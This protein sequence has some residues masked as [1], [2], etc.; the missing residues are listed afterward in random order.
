MSINTENSY[1]YSDLDGLIDINTLGPQATYYYRVQKPV[2][3]NM[4]NF[5][6]KIAFYRANST[7]IYH[8][9]DTLAHW[10][11]PWQKIQMVKWSR[12]GNMAYFYEYKRNEVYDSI[13]LH[14][15]D[16]YCFRIDELKNNFEIVKSL[17]LIDT[18]FDTDSILEKFQSLGLQKHSIYKD[19]LN[20][21]SLFDKILGKSKWHPI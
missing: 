4:S 15:D 16:N 19:E 3:I 10:L 8:R 18:T 7:L 11:E 5:A 9:H 1:R 17:N 2:S 13:F 12:Q 14:L 20:S 6:C 21:K